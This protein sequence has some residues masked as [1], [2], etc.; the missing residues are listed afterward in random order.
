MFTNTYFCINH[1]FTKRV[2]LCLF[3]YIILLLPAIDFNQNMWCYW[4]KVPSP[5]T[6]HTKAQ[7]H[8]CGA[9]WCVGR[10]AGWWFHKQSPEDAPVPAE[11]MTLYPVCAH[12]LMEELSRQYIYFY[13]HNCHCHNIHSPLPPHG[14]LPTFRE[15]HS[16]REII[17]FLQKIQLL[18]AISVIFSHLNAFLSQMK[19]VSLC[20]FLKS[21]IDKWI[22]PT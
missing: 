20:W 1:A 17:H 6:H 18:Y 8:L 12:L 4:R 7:W 22:K 2:C 11:V 16:T 21:M 19:C 3:K 13:W 14:H 5:M 10:R 9:R 15:Q